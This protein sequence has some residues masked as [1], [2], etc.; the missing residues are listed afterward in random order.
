MTDPISNERLLPC[1]F[2]G[3]DGL[4]HNVR[5]TTMWSVSCK[6]CDAGGNGKWTADLAIAAWNRRQSPAGVEVSE[7]MLIDAF[8]RGESWR[9]RNDVD[10]YVAVPEM[11]NKAARDYADATLA[12]LVPHEPASGDTQDDL[13]LADETQGPAGVEP[14]V[15]LSY[16]AFPPDGGDAR[17]EIASPDEDDAFPVY[18]SPPSKAVMITD[19][20]TWFSPEIP[21]S[22]PNGS[23]RYFIVAVRRAQSGNVWTF[24]AIYLNAYPLEFEVCECETEHDE[25][26]PTT[27]WYTASSEGEYDENYSALLSPGD[28]LVAWSEI[29]LHPLDARRAA[30]LSSEA[31]NG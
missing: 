7:Q 10:R 6:N 28:E 3:G 20:V 14:V 17:Y 12:C 27:G 29:Q 8:L 26:C 16:V 18:L 2:C 1:P 15:W 31:H 9:K 5:G 30:A 23:D 4:V 21:P 11:V 24:P 19:E 25:G 13:P 22:I